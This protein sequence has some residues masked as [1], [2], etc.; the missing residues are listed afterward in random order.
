[1]VISSGLRR[2]GLDCARDLEFLYFEVAD[3]SL[4]QFPKEE[5]RIVDKEDPDVTNE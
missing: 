2:K 5:G 3:S 4:S 1:M